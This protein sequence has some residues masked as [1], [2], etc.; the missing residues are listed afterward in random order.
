VAG[1]EDRPGVLY[2]STASM[3]PPP[4][5]GMF[6]P[7]LGHPW[8]ILSGTVFSTLYAISSRFDRRYPCAAPTAGIENEAVLARTFGRAPGARANDGAVPIRSQIWG[9]LVWAGYG[10]H[11]DVIGHFRD[12]VPHAARAEREVK[13]DP[14]HLDWLY[15]GSAFARPQF[16][17]LMDAIAEG[18]VGTV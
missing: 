15:S 18:L 4:A 12:A 7:V 1:V 11:L 5:V 9:R 17:S 10:D 3:A 13:D 2:Q 16:A 6:L 14:P 8:S